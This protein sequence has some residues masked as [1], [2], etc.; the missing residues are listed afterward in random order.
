MKKRCIA[1]LLAL[2]LAP[3]GA[4]AQAPAPTDETVEGPVDAGM[5][6]RMFDSVF[7]TEDIGEQQN[8]LLKAAELAPDDPEMLLSCAQML[9]Y[10]DATGEYAERCEEML[11]HA[12]TIA[13]GDL[14]VAVLQALAEQMVYN[15]KGDD[16]VALMEK[17]VEEDPDNSDMLLSLAIVLYYAD[18][19]EEALAL[20]DAILA[21]MPDNMDAQRLQAN[22]YLDSCMWEEALAA[23][24]RID[25]EFPEYLD[26]LYGVYMTYLASGEFELAVRTID[27][28]L[29]MGADE[30]LWLERARVRLWNQYLPEQALAE[31]T[32]LLNKDPA[33]IDAL[34]V[35]LVSQIMLDDYE[36]AE[37]T[38]GAIADV[39]EGFG[40]VMQ[41]LVM[42]NLGEWEEAEALLRD[43]ID[44]MPEN[45]LAYKNFASLMLDGYDDVDSA[46]DAMRKS[47]AAL[48]GQG[49]SEVYSQLARVYVRQGEYLEAA[50]AYAKA[51][52]L[53]WDDPMPLYD[54]LITCLDAGRAEDATE[55][56]AELERRY[57]GWYE[58]MLGRALW[59]K[60]L[61]NADA[62]LEAFLAFE[63]KFPYPASSMLGSKYTFMAEAGDPEGAALLQAMIEEQGDAASA[64]LWDAYAYAQTVLGNL[65]EAETAL[66]EATDW[67]PIR[68]TRKTAY[69]RSAWISVETTRLEL[70]LEAG[71]LPGA[72]DAVASA[73]SYGWSPWIMLL[74]PER[75]GELIEMEAVQ[76]VLKTLPQMPDEWDLSVP[77]TVPQ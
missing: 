45:Y 41:G 23:Y 62:A 61:G 60:S 34:F 24:Q 43:L 57:P 74:Q 58:T 39:D 21:Q 71:D 63:E 49:D 55:T 36:G 14:R 53:V 35:K 1:L 77:P 30:S 64:L 67:L 66:A 27:T 20:V 26:G 44:R 6:E 13:Q 22:V 32:A 70:C 12:L 69:A 54:L 10:L 46:T 37:E 48:G 28:M 11:Q 15:G 19:N 31:A 72:A 16:A 51:D 5:A 18:H 8:R 29:G 7:A 25:E 2:L 38:A 40:V 56:L 42:M 75:Y 68:R 17:E 76:A 73:V 59:E 52:S 47:F 3:I 9:F 33:W 4:L 65:E 50:R